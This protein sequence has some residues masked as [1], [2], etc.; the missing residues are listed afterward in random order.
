MADYENIYKKRKITVLKQWN[1][2]M[3]QIFKVSATSGREDESSIKLKKYR[4]KFLYN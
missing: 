3:N 4:W 1:L 2:Q